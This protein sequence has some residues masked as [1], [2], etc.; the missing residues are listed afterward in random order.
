MF[1]PVVIVQREHFVASQSVKNKPK[2]LAHNKLCCTIY[3][4]VLI[5]LVIIDVHA[6]LEVTISSVTGDSDVH[7]VSRIMACFYTVRSRCS[8]QK[9]AACAERG[10]Y[11]RCGTPSV[12]LRREPLARPE[13][14]RNAHRPLCRRT[15]AHDGE[16]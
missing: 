2:F 1:L 12:V 9:L 5:L 13:V 4:F 7:A 16:C 11:V 14:A 3:P 6:R 10:S 15:E 8:W